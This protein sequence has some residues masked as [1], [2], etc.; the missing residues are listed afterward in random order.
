MPIV[1]GIPDKL[2]NQYEAKWLVRQLFDV[3]AGKAEWIRFEGITLEFAGFEFALKRAG[4]TEWHQTKSNA[5]NGNWTIRALERENVLS[6]FKRRLESSSHDRC[7]FVSQ[8]PAKDFYALVNSAK[9]ANNLGEFNQA[10]SAGHKDKFA[11][12][13]KA[14][15]VED[16][17]AYAWIK[18]C[19]SLTFPESEL[20]ATI[21]SYSDLYFSPGSMSAFALLRAYAEDHFNK[22]LTTEVI[23]ADLL[24]EGSLCLKDWALDPTLRERTL[25][26]TNEYLRTYS[27]FGAGGSTIPRRQIAELIDQ[28]TKPDGAKVVLLTG[29]AGSGKSGIVRGF[30]GKLREL[31]VT[32]LALR[33]D[34]HLDRG[35]PQEVGKA[36]T[37]RDESPVSTLKGLE[38]ER[39]SVLI[40]D[41]V[42]AVSEVSGRSGTVKEA[43]LRMVNDARSLKTV[44]LVLVCRSFD[45][46]NDP[47]LKALKQDNS[48]EQIDVPLL[49]WNDEVAPLL[50]SRGVDVNQ[51]SPA[52]KELLCVPLNLAIFLEVGSEGQGFASRNDLLQALMQR[53]DRS[54]RTGRSVPWTV[55]KPLTTLARWM[56]EQQTLDAPE[57][58]LDDYPSALDILASEGLV[59]R[60]RNRVN[61]FHECFFD[62]L[63]TRVF[64]SGSQTLLD[65][66]TSTE[67][68]LFRRTQTRQILEALRQDDPNRYLREV[69]SVLTSDRTRY[70]VKAAVAQWLGSLSDPTET[71]RE[72]ILRLDDSHRP[73]NPLV[74]YAA[75]SSAGWFDRLHENGWVNA[76]L[77][78]ESEE[79]RQ[80][81]LWWLSKI[82]GQRPSD[83]AKLLDSWWDNNPERG[84]Q[85]LSWFGFVTR[86]R[87]DQALVAFC[88]KVIRSKPPGLFENGGRNK[89]EVILVTWVA[90]TP[91]DGAMILK[92]L[93]DAW[94]DAHPG[95]HPFETNVLHELDMYW[96]G[97]IAQKSPIAFIT[98]TVDALLLSI[99]EINRREARGER[100]YSFAHRTFS[101]HRFGAD[102]F[103]G[104]F[105]SALRQVASADPNLAQRFL[106]T[107][108][109]SKHEALLHLHLDAVCAN[110]EALGGHLLEILGN[111]YLFE[112]GWDGADWKSFADAARAAF[113]YFSTDNRGRVERIIFSCNPEIE[114]A[115]RA[116]HEIKEHGEIEPWSNRRSILWDLN[117]S[118]FEQWCVLETIGKD[119]LTND[120]VQYLKRLRRKFAGQ[121]VPEPSHVGVHDVGPPIKRDKT[122]KMDDRNWL[123]AITRYNSENERRRGQGFTDGGARELAQEL[124]HATK[125]NASRFGAF[126]K[127]IPNDAHPTYVSHILWGL[128]EAQDVD[129]GILIEAIFEAHQRSERP[130]GTEI[131]RLLEKRPK[132][133]TDPSVFDTLVW[134]IENGDASEDERIDASNTEREIAS[135]DDL[136][137]Q[138]TRLHVR[139]INGTRGWA[140]EAM[141][142]VIWNVPES[143]ARAWEVL[144]R[145]IVREQLG[146]VRCCLMRPLVSLFN[147]DQ[148]RCAQLVELLIGGPSEANGDKG[149]ETPDQF[150]S[151]LITHH[152]IYLLPFLQHWVP[153][154]GRRLMDRLLNSGDET[155]R[156]IGAW[157]VFNGSFQDSAY[158]AEADRY[159]EG[160]HVY[161]RL[162]AGV[163][164]DAITREEF[165]KRAEEQLVRF[166][167]DEDDQ[168]CKRAANVFRH[169]EPGDF[170]RFFDIAR[171]YIASRA[172]ELDSFA[173]FH[174]LEEAECG[175][176]ELVISAAEKLLA[177]SDANNESDG[178]RQLD[179]HQLQGLLKREYAASEKNPEL[180]KRLLNVIDV[181]LQKELYGTEE[182]VKAHERE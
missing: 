84:N 48:V 104:L 163:A 91:D 170:A 173:F 154:I 51:L 138:G 94:F 68:H 97:Q 113:P 57:S 43:V 141:A 136:L 7:F 10:L 122:V 25:G 114:R 30:I 130:Y 44:C 36:L 105:R 179:L 5:P 52:Q 27:P 115:I 165:R 1:G 111:E 103:L 131:A 12:L 29:I 174:A 49:V 64:V 139:G 47:R 102:E 63:Y 80:T 137:S 110:G 3:I 112:G 77:S 6:A 20:E 26:E 118:G 151:P 86:Q 18:R 119:L 55:V 146:S 56:S 14:W 11:Q 87:P 50:A 41:Q 85:L 106:S 45:F 159:I 81:M 166:F 78:G 148:L 33:V 23:K 126:L 145:R 32:H 158:A 37:G 178:R 59:V 70:H 142:A 181:M 161:R 109:V 76:V 28:V 34:H 46:D 62:Y 53:K 160:S 65:L 90:K 116:A 121:K 180:R 127:R 54:I 129:D 123:H 13:I 69:E 95:Q 17:T 147:N 176:C 134:Y 156:M 74:R 140:A 58:V 38:P 8:D 128:I 100:D 144:E 143:I 39:V 73:F 162:A 71:E 117:W 182:I 21:A 66:L 107:L 16:V 168:V 75:L 92:A 155:I 4:V 132:L 31:D 60:S 108:D 61:F 2:G 42:D 35:T 89:R 82:A 133:A 125:E 172:F 171:K 175:V 9:I 88:E 177:S 15:E 124:Q 120:G 93:L 22:I 101:G 153:E 83:T 167:Y 40:V 96:L 99:D 149:Q 19:E 150:L 79:R 157:H 164:S 67:Q 24:E 135:I 152:G 169:I 98:G 72:I